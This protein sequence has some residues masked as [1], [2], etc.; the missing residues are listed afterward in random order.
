MFA[1]LKSSSGQYNSPTGQAYQLDGNP[2][3]QYYDIKRPIGSA[4]PELAWKVYDAIRKT[5]DKVR[6]EKNFLLHFHDD[7]LYR[8]AS[9][10]IAFLSVINFAKLELE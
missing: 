5:D 2:I 8:L 1:K 9:A 7:Y 6:W 4:G 3:G 10:L